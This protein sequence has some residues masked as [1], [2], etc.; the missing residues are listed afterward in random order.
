MESATVLTPTAHNPRRWARLRPFAL[1]ILLFSLALLLRVVRLTSVP[2]GFFCDEASNVLDAQALNHTLHDRTGALLPAYFKALGDWR[3][4]LHIY[5]MTPFV[6]IFG[7][8]E[9]AA[10]LASAVAGAL[11]VSLTYA[12]VRRASGRR[13]A[14]WS[15]LLLAVSPWHLMHSRVGWEVISVPFITALFLCLFYRGLVRPIYL[16]PAFAAAVSGMYTY[17]PGRLF[18]PLLSVAVMVVYFRPLWQNLARREACAWGLLLGFVLLIPTFFAIQ[19]GIFFARLQQIDLEPLTLSQRLL[20]FGPNYLEHFSAQFLFTGLS[21]GIWR[22]SV[23]GYGMLY[24]FQA[25]FVLVGLWA[26]LRRRNRADWLWLAWLAIYPIAAALVAAPVSTRSITGV[27]V[28]QIVTAQGIVTALSLLRIAAKAL[29]E[30]R[31]RVS[32]TATAVVAIICCLATTSFMRAYLVE[33]P[34]YSSGFFG[35]QWGPKPILE[36]FDAH[37]DQYDNL[38]LNAEY[39]ESAVLM[40]FFSSPRVAQSGKTGVTD[41]RNDELLKYAYDPTQ[42]QLWA[43]GAH[44][45]KGT[46]LRNYRLNLVHRIYYPDGTLAFNLVETGPQVVPVPVPKWHAPMVRRGVTSATRR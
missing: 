44:D 28:F 31:R 43:V 35:W 34:K 36:Y 1:P 12:F 17:Q 10:R 30:W 21:D 16:I 39:N 20:A 24:W 23:S 13:V 11:T 2:L 32:H 41:V 14:L 46:K 29:P 40:H 27:V 19:S 7:A 25:P 45:W 22:H 3:G 8:T 15:A 4:G 37:I 42:R 6:A 26:M 18:F 9:L 5:W 38:W 33:Y